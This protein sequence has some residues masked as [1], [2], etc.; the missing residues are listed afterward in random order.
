MIFVGLTVGSGGFSGFLH[1]TFRRVERTLAGTGGWQYWQFNG[2]CCGNVFDTAGANR[3]GAQAMGAAHA[4][5]AGQ[6]NRA[7][8]CREFVQGQH[9]WGIVEKI[10]CQG[11]LGGQLAV[12]G[13][14]VI[15]GQ[16][17]H[18]DGEHA[19][20]QLEHGILV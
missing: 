4:H 20:F 7:L 2:D 13:V 15:A 19:A 10:R 18:G 11:D 6:I 9:Q 12:E 1:F 8:A 5:Q 16:L 3:Q 14:E 17:Q